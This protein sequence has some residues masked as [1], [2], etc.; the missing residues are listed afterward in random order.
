MWSCTCIRVC[1]VSTN[2]FII[3]LTNICNF[4]P[5]FMSQYGETVEVSAIFHYRFSQI[6]LSGFVCED[7]KKERK[8]ERKRIII[9]CVNSRWEYDTLHPPSGYLLSLHIK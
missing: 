6:Q 4:Q 5:V 8:K 1:Y 9:D 3:S 7:R 2:E